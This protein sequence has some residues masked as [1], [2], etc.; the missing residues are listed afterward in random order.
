MRIILGWKTFGRQGNIMKSFLPMC[1]K[2]K[3]YVAIFLASD[4]EPT[5]IVD[6]RLRRTHIY[7]ARY[8]SAG[9]KNCLL[10]RSKWII[11]M[12]VIDKIAQP[13]NTEFICRE[14]I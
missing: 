14:L 11:L 2:R 10:A 1:L 6:V 7:L 9:K 4:S 8:R 12:I 13:D 3:V 5:S